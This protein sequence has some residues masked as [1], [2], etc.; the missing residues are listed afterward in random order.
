MHLT[1]FSILVPIFLGAFLFFWKPKSALVRENYVISATVTTSLLVFLTINQTLRFGT[2][3]TAV[4]LVEFENLLSLSLRIDRAGMVFAALIA[5]L[6][7]ITT[8]YAFEY[9]RHAGKENKFFA[10]FL[11]SY[12]VVVGIAFA[13][14]FLTLYI[15]YEMMTLST[16]PLV[17]HD[18]SK[19]AA[20]AGRKYLIYSFSGAA[21]VF[22]LIVFLMH[23]GVNL[24][25]T[26]GGLLDME[27]VAG[28][29]TVLR[30]MFV[31]A[32]F[33]FGVKA[34]VVP[35]HSWLP[36]AAVAPTPVTALLH[37]VA[38]VKSGA[39][40]IMRLIYFGFGTAFL[41]GTWAQDVCLLAA[42]ATILY[43]SAQAVRTPHFKR[44]L[45]YSTVS[46]LSYIVFA[47]A[48]MTPAGMAAGLT[49]MVFHAV[50]KITLFF[51]AGAVLVQSNREYVYELGGMGRKMKFTFAAYLA[52]AFG[53]MGLPPFG[54]F[55]GKWVIAT[56]AI[57][58]GS[59]PA[60][61]GVAALLLSALLMVLYLMGVAVEAYFPRS[62]VP[63]ER[64]EG[65]V[66]AGGHMRI[67]YA[68]LTV[69]AVGLALASTGLADFFAMAAWGV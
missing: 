2:G 8:V 22:V 37:A 20:F 17:T 47:F 62:D 55:I 52:A 43:G 34:A 1:A 29:E 64:L 42:A 12:G 50:L 13:E 4:T 61:F 63:P 33:G 51:C 36:D 69:L 30:I 6:W 54:G 58:E 10:F 66:E 44:R 46:N 32:F 68:I 25:F 14:D 5:V 67:T 39:F 57:A 35:F 45:A 41:R 60:L 65:V 31:I 9:M 24:N 38:V 16:L 21:V 3:E 28:N 40:A 26:P 15:F 19:E 53:L 49:H 59:S 23:Y 27:K 11:A 18:G 48:L 56:A 7:P